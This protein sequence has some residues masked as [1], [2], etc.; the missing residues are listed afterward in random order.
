M[1]KGHHAH[2]RRAYGRRQHELR[3]RRSRQRAWEDL[4]LVTRALD[5]DHLEALEASA[6]RF[7]RTAIS[8][9]TRWAAETG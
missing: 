7:P 1:A 6:P 8:F 3:E 4:P 2:R 9:G 5:E